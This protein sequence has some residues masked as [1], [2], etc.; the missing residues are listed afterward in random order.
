MLGIFLTLLAVLIVVCVAFYFSDK[1]GARSQLADQALFDR[2]GRGKGR[3]SR[4]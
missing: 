1:P 3:E 4:Q 2:P